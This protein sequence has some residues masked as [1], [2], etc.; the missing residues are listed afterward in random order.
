[1]LDLTF[2]AIE[3]AA[4]QTY[5][6]NDQPD[7]Y[8]NRVESEAKP[9]Q[10]QSLPPGSPR[11]SLIQPFASGVARLVDR[12]L[13]AIQRVGAHI[14]PRVSSSSNK[15]YGEACEDSLRALEGVFRSTEA[16]GI[17]EQLAHF[18]ECRRVI[19]NLNP[20]IES[21]NDSTTQ[22][23]FSSL[24]N[25]IGKPGLEKLSACK[26]SLERG[27]MKRDLPEEEQLR[28]QYMWMV[29]ANLIEF[30][31]SESASLIRMK[32]GNPIT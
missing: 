24:K 15:K 32:S 1:M 9:G 22:T 6:F 4:Y 13:T 17:F 21:L 2:H 10:Y 31:K 20:A 19:A 29:V 25:L 7:A 16:A 30:G 11:V 28:L 14:F 5:I 26:K 3:Y 23:Y 8:A 12:I 27:C 18:C